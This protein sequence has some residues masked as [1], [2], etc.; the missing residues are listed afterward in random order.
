M[1]QTLLYELLTDA[2]SVAEVD[3]ARETYALRQRRFAD[4]LRAHGVEARAADGINTWLA[5]P[6]EREAIVRLT[7]S[8]I[9]VAPGGPFL[10]GEDP[11]DGMGHVRVT[12]GV[13]GDDPAPVAAAFAA[14]T[15]G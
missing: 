12:V 13:A 14:A 3:A 2:E 6:D 7:A 9:R 4:A 10:L 11:A 1:T 15:R 5:V 8:G